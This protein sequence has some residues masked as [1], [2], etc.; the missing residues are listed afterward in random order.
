[1]KSNTLGSAIVMTLAVAFSSCLKSPE[2][3]TPLVPQTYISIMHLAATAPPVDVYFDDNKVSNTAFPPGAV[4]PSYNSIDKGAFAIKFKKANSDSLVSQVPVAEYDSM[5][6][7]TIFI[8][9]PQANG[10]A[11]A[12][13][14]R[15]DFTEVLGNQTKP[16]YRF[17]HGSSNTGPVDFY[18]NGVKIESGRTNADNT[19]LEALNKFLS[20]VHL[21]QPV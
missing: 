21:Y 12:I 4:T 20:L 16:Y 17:F 6:Y 8:Y 19:Q 14:I 5:K 11:N 18:L 1:M 2:N 3:T 7:Y 13:R 10:P 15:D 9:H